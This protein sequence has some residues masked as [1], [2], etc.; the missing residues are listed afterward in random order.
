MIRFSNYQI[1][2]FPC[3]F[4]ALFKF[5]TVRVVDIYF[6]FTVPVCLPSICSDLTATFVDDSYFLPRWQLC[7]AKKIKGC[8]VED[9]NTAA[10]FH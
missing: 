1:Q 5:G 7:N 9:R 6:P 2:K 4:S 3:S 8:Q 10:D